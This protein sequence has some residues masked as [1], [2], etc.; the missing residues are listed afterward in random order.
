MTM[1]SLR[2]LLLASVAGAMCAQQGYNPADVQAGKQLY[3]VNCS[4]CHGPKGDN[5]SGVDLGH[6]TFRRASTD[7]EVVAIMVQG[8]NG[9]PMPP[10]NLS[11]QQ[12]HQVVAYLR[13]LAAEAGASTASKANLAHGKAL[14]ESNGCLNC[15]RIG[16]HGSR[17]GPDLTGIGARRKPADIERSIVDPNAEILPENRYVQV[18]TRDGVTVTG[19]ILNEDTFS[20]QLIDSKEKLLSLQKADLSKFEFLKNSAMPSY[21]DKLSGNELS[22]LV[23]YLFSLKGL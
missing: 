3:G 9:T 19:R 16:E 23:S 2:F 18:V 22:D 10:A 7:N 5:V 15:H 20:L 11:D 17:V 14:F 12:A 4:H 1:C 21:R 13:S 8:I 6:G